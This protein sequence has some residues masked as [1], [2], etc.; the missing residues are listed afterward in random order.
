MIP[1]SRQSISEADIKEVNRVLRS[2]FLTQGPEVPLFEKNLSSYF[3]AKHAICCSSG[4]AALH[5]AYASLGANK[6]SVTIVPAITFVSTANASRH[7]G[8]KIIFCD[9]DP[10]SGI[11]SMD[12]LE[13]ILEESAKSEAV[14]N[15]FIC[16]V[17]LAG[18][19]APLD[20]IHDLAQKYQFSLIEDASHAFGART[21]CKDSAKIIRSG[22]CNLVDAAC[23]SF[24]PV[25]HLCCGEGGV[26]LTNSD[27]ISKKALGLRSHGI[28]RTH[29][30][31]H[32][33]PWFYEQVDLGW[34]YRMTDIQA[35]LGNSQIKR[36][37]ESIRKRREIAKRYHD[38][39]S[40]PKFTER[41]S[42]PVMEDGHAWHLYVIRFHQA[43]DRDQ[44][45]KFL[46]KRGIMS[47]IHYIPL[48]RH[49]YYQKNAPTAPLLGA[50]TYFERC[51]SIPLYPEL[52]QTEQTEVIEALSDFISG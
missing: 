29:N 36:I 11:I 47:Q 48:Y 26:L 38:A 46:I 35:A 4:T 6:E 31:N 40:E 42:P 21:D 39:F 44:A 8:S 51:L 9:V 25:K 1:Y 32:D 30:Q 28:Q 52:N 37:D 45:Y 20:H 33:R 49:P 50:E 2:D 10:V 41:F 24:H 5:L 15:G 7:L 34:N 23:L 18:K 19:T 22:D 27:K 12:H 13:K 16:P 3:E 14:K 17:S 43:K